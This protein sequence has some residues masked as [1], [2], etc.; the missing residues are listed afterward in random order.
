M[1]TPIALPPTRRGSRTVQG[2]RLN[3]TKP[4]DQ[5]LDDR[6]KRLRQEAKGTPPGV[7]REILIRRARQAETAAQMQQWILSPA[8]RPP[9]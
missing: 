5:R 2:R 1:R 3:Q 6:A 8:L 7:A 9:K 4:L